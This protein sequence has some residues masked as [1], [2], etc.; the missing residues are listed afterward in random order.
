MTVYEIDFTPALAV[1]AS[2]VP[3]SIQQ[4]WGSI[5]IIFPTM[6]SDGT[7]RWA[8]DLSTGKTTDAIIP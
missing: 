6:N 5:D 8:V 4:A 2:Q 3:A 1:V 7:L